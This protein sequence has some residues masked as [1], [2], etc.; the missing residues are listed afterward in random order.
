MESI[1][2]DTQGAQISCRQCGYDVRG[3]SV[4]GVCPE[5]GFLVERSLASD[6]LKNSSPEYLASLHRGVVIILTS[7]IL[8][9]LFMFVA[10]GA[11]IAI[12]V[13]S[14]G[15]AVPAW[16]NI[17]NQVVNVVLSL[18]IVYGW[19]LF[20]APDPAFTGREDGSTARRVV[21]ITLC[22]AVG[23]SF[24]SLAINFL[25][26]NQATGIVLIGVGVLSLVVF[27]VRYFAEML[28][29]RWL[30]PRI[31][32]WDAHKRAKLLLWLGPLLYIVGSLCLGLGPLVALVLYWNLLDKIRKDIKAIRQAVPGMTA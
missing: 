29:L 2:V 16:F 27:G 24:L 6:E 4:D 8:M 12:A 20:S 32:N 9:I 31:P 19:W 28:Y 3:L 30:T 15:G 1:R 5:C 14:R 18:A 10:I 11:V 25:P 23:L 26:L 13:S 22:I 21:R 7:I 17:A